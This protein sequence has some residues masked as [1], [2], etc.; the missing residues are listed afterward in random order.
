MQN[1]LFLELRDGMTRDRFR[2]CDHKAVA[3]TEGDDDRHANFKFI[4]RELDL[5]PLKVLNVYMLKHLHAYLHFCKT[6]EQAGDGIDQTIMDIQNYMDLAFTLIQ[7]EV[8]GEEDVRAD[9]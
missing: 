3:Y 1:D 5:S 9:A 7:E 8:C 2:M 6:G 4:A